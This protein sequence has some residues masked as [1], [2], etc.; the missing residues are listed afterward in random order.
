[1]FG[2]VAR[3]AVGWAAG[4]LFLSIP[5][6]ILGPHILPPIA[7]SLGT[8]HLLY[9]SLDGVLTWMPLLITIAALLKLIA[10]G[11]SEGRPI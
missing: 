10:A 3:T 11:V 9:T 6:A 5:A 7:D 4:Q 1:M 2:A 8:A